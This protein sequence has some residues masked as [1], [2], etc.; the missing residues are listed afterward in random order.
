MECSMQINGLSIRCSGCSMQIN[1]LSAASTHYEQLRMAAAGT[2]IQQR[3]KWSGVAA[4]GVME[5]GC[6]QTAWGH[7]RHVSTQLV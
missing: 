5:G 4:T 1:G 6:L 2:T 7:V 3:S